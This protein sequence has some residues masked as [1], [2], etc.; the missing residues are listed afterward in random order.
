MDPMTITAMEYNRTIAQTIRHINHAILIAPSWFL[1]TLDGIWDSAYSTSSIVL[2][3]V[4]VELL[5]LNRTILWIKFKLIN[6]LLDDYFRRVSCTTV[7]RRWCPSFWRRE[8]TERDGIFLL[9]WINTAIPIRI[10]QKNSKNNFFKAVSYQS[11][12]HIMAGG[13]E[14]VSMSSLKTIA[15]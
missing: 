10:N 12:L 1:V 15:S 6:I 7:K 2:I 13:K 3:N 5:L 8:K 14:R 4:A 9:N 11:L